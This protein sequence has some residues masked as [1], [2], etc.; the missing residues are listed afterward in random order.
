MKVAAARAGML[1]AVVL[2]SPG[3]GEN[4]D[5]RTPPASEPIRRASFRSMAAR[6]FLSS[7]PEGATRPETVRQVARFEELKAF[8]RRKGG[9]RSIWLG[10]NDW[11]AVA[12]RSDRESCEAGEQA[13]GQALAAFSGTLDELAGRIAR[14]PETRP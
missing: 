12:Q 3:C 14:E 10:E 6:D 1:S 9:G 8:A 5:E 7:C 13:Y 11:A 2:L 4:P